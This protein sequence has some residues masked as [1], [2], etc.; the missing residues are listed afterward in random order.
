MYR[1]LHYISKISVFLLLSSMLAII[2]TT[3]ISIFLKYVNPYFE[4]ISLL[5]AGI[6]V[7]LFAHI[8]SPY[9]KYNKKERM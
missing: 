3:A 8:D 6:I 2:F 7:L 4:Y 9:N 1:V 5:I